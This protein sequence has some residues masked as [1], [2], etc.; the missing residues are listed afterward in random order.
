MKL[1]RVTGI[2]M[3]CLSLLP[4]Q[5][6]TS[7][8]RNSAMPPVRLDGPYFSQGGKRFF[9][10]GAHWVPAKAALQWPKQWQPAAIETDFRRMR[11]LGF[12]TVRLDLFWAWFEP[13]PGDY[14]PAAF[15]QLD[16]LIGLAHKYGMYL[17]PALFIGGEVGDAFWDVPW[18][19]GRDPHSDPEMLRLE[20]NHAA[21]LARRY[22]NESAIIAWDLTDE[23]PFWIVRGKTTDAVAINWTRLI[24]GAIRRFDPLHVLCVG[25]DVEDITRGPFR[26]DNI[27]DEVD[28]FS[29]HPYPIYN[30]ALFPDSMLSE[31]MTYAAA[32]QTAL[33][34]GAGK[35]VMIQEIGASSAQYSPERIAAY[36][37]ANLYSGLAAGANGF[38]VWTF[39]DAA[40]ETYR[41]IPYLRAPHETQFG[42]T[43]WDGRPR[44]RG[45]E[46]QRFSK[47]LA[48]IDLSGIAPAF[49]EAGI[50]VPTEWSEPAGDYSGFGL[51]GP[52]DIPYVSTQESG[53]ES[54]EAGTLNT[55]V[56]GSWLSTFICA[57]RAGLKVA[58]PRENEDWHKYPIIFLPSPGA[59]TSNNM[60]HVRTTFWE[61]ARKYVEGGGVLYVSLSGDSAIPDM[62]EFLGARPADHAP[63]DDVAIKVSVPFGGLAAGD[64]LRY[65]ASIENPRQ[66]AA[67]LENRGGTV[68]ATDQDGRPALIR[69]TYG[70]GKVLVCAYPLESYLATLPSAFE[71][72]EETFRLYQALWNWSGIKPL[73]STNN[74]EVEVSGLAGERRGYAVLVNHSARPQE[75]TVTAKFTVRSVQQVKPDGVSP[76]PVDGDK[77][78]VR[79]EPYDGTVVEW[80]E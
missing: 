18:R 25:T 31:R 9:P 43:T 50:V 57:R 16:Y 32:F 71:K 63:V 60:M 12:N 7:D 14:N 80:H 74:P 40:P 4:A 22:R 39:T 5:T 61:R 52:G 42:L 1:R 20:T 58:F 68:I 44:P 23:P 59:S 11:D 53:P 8:L 24:A 69:H 27:R 70:A 65:R 2:A 19:N 77:W 6:V 21:E 35:P 17:H 47:I 79:V 54:P 56:V 66:W 10:V 45:I 64:T 38:L 34:G 13:R 62:D 29:V 15:E 49:A 73:L 36:E 37:R 3:T 26:P 46:M 72:T 67:V 41:R 48:R 30:L 78:S 28:Y 55:G 51:K 76:V 75:V 33:S